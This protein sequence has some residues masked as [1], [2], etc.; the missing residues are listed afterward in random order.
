MATT[1]SPLAMEATMQKDVASVCR[2]EQ[3]RPMGKVGETADCLVE[4]ITRQYNQDITVSYLVRIRIVTI[5]SCP[6]GR[7]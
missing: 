5:V 2:S 4:Q 7:T 6:G 3:C 1:A